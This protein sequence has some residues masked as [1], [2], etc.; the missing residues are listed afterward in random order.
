MANFD[1]EGA[2]L[3]TQ[4]KQL[5][6]NRVASARAQTLSGYTGFVAQDIDA[7]SRFCVQRELLII[8]RCPD[9][10]ANSYVAEVKDGSYR[11]KPSHI[12]K[13]TGEHGLLFFGGRAYV[14]D[15][16][17]MCVH[18][19]N[20]KTGSYEAV[21]LTWNGKSNKT[22][23]EEEIIGTLNRRLIFKLQH[24]CNANYVVTSADGRSSRPKNP[25][26]GDEFLAFRGLDVDFVMGKSALRS[27]YYMRYGLS[28]WHQAYGY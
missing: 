28:G 15:Y 27:Q 18:R 21:P 22:A 8:F 1:K 16:D 4:A 2:V 11:M 6:A 20:R 12:I 7:I 13:K 5:P 17:F 3:L 10:N 19:L 26:I 9:F 14:S 24:G 23:A 25:N